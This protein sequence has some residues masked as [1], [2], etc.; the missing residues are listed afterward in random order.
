MTERISEPILNKKKAEQAILYILNKCG[1]M[2]E[3]KLAT[4]LYLL[5]LTITRDMRNI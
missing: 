3:K 2:T 4:M 5:I 1:S